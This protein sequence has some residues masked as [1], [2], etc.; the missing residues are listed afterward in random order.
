MAKK[1]PAMPGE[2]LLD[3]YTCLLAHFGPQHWWPGE[4]R[5]EI[6]VGA[7]LTQNT[8]WRN[9][10]RALAD[11]KRANALDPARMRA[12]RMDRLARLIRPAGFY[13]A[14]SK[15]LKALVEFLFRE[16]DGD[17]ARMV[18]GDLS[19]QRTRLLALDGIGPETADAILLYAAE[20][21]IFV[22]DAYTRRILARLGLARANAG[23]DELQQL[24]MQH[25]PH[26]V[27]LFN[28]YHALLDTLGKTTCLKRQPRCSACPLDR[29]CPKVGVQTVDA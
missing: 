12:L 8:A 22:V 24:F 4:S 14:K 16:Y 15:R 20:Q 26:E 17:A 28:E 29:I 19:Q 23:Y 9:V 25:L 13:R 11:L 18:G 3:I 7:I 27:A 1:C 21:P 10:E 5:W 6:M 2:K